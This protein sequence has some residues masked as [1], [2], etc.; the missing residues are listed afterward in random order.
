MADLSKKQIERL[1]TI[2]ANLVRAKAFYMRPD[3]YL[4]TSRFTH[5]E[6]APNGDQYEI[7]NKAISDAGEAPQ[8]LQLL[9]K[10]IGSDMYGLFQAL[11]LLDEFLANPTLKVKVQQE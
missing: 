10:D 7:H 8:R 11:S 6:I 4:A 3:N 1:K 2:R 9:T 5:L